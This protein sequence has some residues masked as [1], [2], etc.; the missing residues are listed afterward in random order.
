MEFTN[1]TIAPYVNSSNFIDNL[2]NKIIDSLSFSKP[3]ISSLDGEVKDLILNNEIGCFCQNNPL[4]WFKSINKL[5][6][7]EVLYKKLCRNAKMLYDKK[8]SYNMVYK[9][10]VEI[11][12]KKFKENFY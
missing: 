12:E 4:S 9:K 6:E 8:F 1:A 3:V 10:F 2:P 7:D 11:V 5:I